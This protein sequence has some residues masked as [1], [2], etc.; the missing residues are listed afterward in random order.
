MCAWKDFRVLTRIGAVISVTICATHPRQEPNHKALHPQTQ[1]LAAPAQNLHHPCTN[2]PKH[3]RLEPHCVSDEVAVLASFSGHRCQ[4]PPGRMP[5]TNAGSVALRV[6]GLLGR[7]RALELRCRAAGLNKKMKQ[8]L[9]SLLN[10]LT[11]RFLLSASSRR[12]PANSRARGCR[13]TASSRKHRSERRAC[14]RL[15]GEALSPFSKSAK[16]VDA[17]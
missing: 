13:C 8:D 15:C 12:P 11:D 6:C 10:H 1:P 5:Q 14:A 7:L 17:T 16:T 2:I 4:K 3:G 9:R